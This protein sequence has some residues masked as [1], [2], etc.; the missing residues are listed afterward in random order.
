MLKTNVTAT[1][2]EVMKASAKGLIC[3][4][5]ENYDE[6][7]VY[8]KSIYKGNDNGKVFKAESGD[9]VTVLDGGYDYVSVVITTIK[10]EDTKMYEVAAFD[11]DCYKDR[12]YFDDEYLEHTD[13]DTAEEYF[14]H[15]S[16]VYGNDVYLVTQYGK[17]H[18]VEEITGIYDTIEQSQRDGYFDYS[19][20]SVWDA[21]HYDTN[22][23]TPEE[24]DI[25]AFAATQNGVV[26]TI[27]RWIN[28]GYVVSRVVNADEFEDST[29]WYRGEM[30]L[31]T[32][33]TNDVLN[34]IRYGITNN[35][36]N[37]DGVIYD[38]EEEC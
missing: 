2:T 6:A 1:T 22:T 12:Y 4:C 16:V 38:V 30:Q 27:L 20:E 34:A 10:V 9:I 8:A 37:V 17:V 7:L 3:K 5:F 14:E 36:I 32:T 25:I 24:L 28:K 11:K 31:C 23:L 26:P 35:S 33:H 19:P 15:Y 13:K 29:K 18:T 21:A